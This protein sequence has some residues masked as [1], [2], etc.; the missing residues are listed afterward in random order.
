MQAQD[1]SDDDFYRPNEC[2][3]LSEDQLRLRIA[4]LEQ[5]MEAEISAIR[6]RY[7]TKLIDLRSELTKQKKKSE[8]NKQTQASNK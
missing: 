6:M 7:E 5:S 1:S 2:Q 4:Q 8:K 3:D